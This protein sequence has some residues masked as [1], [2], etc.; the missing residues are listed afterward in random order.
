VNIRRLGSRNQT[1][2]K[3][4]EAVAMLADEAL[5]PDLKRKQRHI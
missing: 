4:D 2:M 5:P 3:L 1:S